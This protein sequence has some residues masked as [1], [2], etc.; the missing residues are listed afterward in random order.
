ML[1][2]TTENG[3]V[4]TFVDN[5]DGSY[6]YTFA[7]DI[8]N[9]TD[10]EPI[11]YEPTLT[12]RVTFEIRGLVPVRNP[13]FDFRPS[14]DATDGLFSRNIVTMERCNDCHADLA[15]HG[16]A[17]FETQDCVT[18]HNPG[19]ADANSGNTLDMTVMTHKLHR[20]IYLPSVINGGDYCI[21]GFRDS[22]HCYNDVIYPQDIRNCAN[23]H[24]ESDPDTPDAENWYLRPTAQSCGSCHD[25]V[26]FANGDNHGPGIPASNAECVTCHATDPNSS[27]E[28]RQAHRMLTMELRANYSFNLLDINFSG[29]GTAPVAIF[30]VTDPANGDAPYDLS[31]DADLLASSLRMYVA[32]NTVDYSNFFSGTDNGQPE[33]SNVYENGVLQATDNGDGS[34]SLGL[35]SVPAGVM[36]SGV[37]TFEGNVST[38]DGRV[39][40]TTA[41]AYFAI[42]DDPA[43]PTA[44]R[45]K[46]DMDRCNDCHEVVSFHGSSRNDSIES[47]QICHNANAARS[48]DPSAG[49]MDMK[50]FLHR[51]HAVD[52]IRYPQPVSN[53]TGCHTDDGF[54]PVASD[55]G[56]FAASFNRGT[57]SADATDNN[58]ASANATTCGVCH[59]SSDANAHMVSNGAW[60]DA[61][62]ETDGTTLE[63]VDFCGPG[64]NK[65]GRLVQ[66][67][68][69]VCH[70]PGR[71]SDTGT[72]HGL[73]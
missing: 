16:G 27:L 24:N 47:C 8:T 70:G 71:I 53:C 28:V 41:H 56:V 72:A 9:V 39:P 64:G 33:R 4:G 3:S 63:R 57:N 60:L 5:N 34:Y 58:R 61:C 23:C 65:S 42:T 20:G 37:V 17:R 13:H 25:D 18:C 32:W 36:G 69:T 52:D 55:S 66:E 26:N 10:P 44:R 2:A 68:C 11:S 38:V 48:G 1:Q 51:K 21:Y 43:N 31:S 14:D 54:Y 62:M 59:S 7:L 46:V 50:H 29:P 35:T 15:F 49:P 45:S 40:V 12:H 73:Q 22:L 67:S 30:S 19:S 6:V